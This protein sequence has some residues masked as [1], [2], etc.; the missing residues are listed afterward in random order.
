MSGLSRRQIIQGAAYLSAGTLSHAALALP[1]EVPLHFSEFM[2]LSQML[3][4]KRMLHEEVGLRIYYGL[5]EA[6]GN[7]PKLNV[8][9]RLLYQPDT[10]G[11]QIDDLIAK[12][13]MTDE[14][15]RSATVIV[16]AWYTGRYGSKNEKR[17]ATYT[18][19]LMYR[20]TL[21]LHNIPTFCGGPTGYWA[22]PPKEGGHVP[23]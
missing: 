14:E 19:A 20:P 23:L 3:T 21:G 8:L 9:R 7:Q 13:I 2:R 12:Q 22:E 18:H 4:G 17:L 5:A 10:S 6:T 16:S 11:L 1:G 15:C